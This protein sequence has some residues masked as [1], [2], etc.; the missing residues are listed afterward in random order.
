V[1]AEKLPIAMCSALS[2][3]N[4]I[5]L[6]GGLTAELAYN[7]ILAIMDDD[8]AN[9]IGRIIEGFEVS[10]ET[11][12]LDTIASIGIDGTFLTSPM[13]RNLWKS[14]DYMPK[15]FDKSSYQEWINSGKKT[16]LDNAKQRY[17]EILQTHKP[18][19][20]DDDTDKEITKILEKATKYYKEKGLI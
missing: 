18:K 7:P 2:G 16:L 17:E 13:T 1:G 5:V 15:I 4:L 8:I 11:I 12:G 6:H 10:D 3:A 9:T 19:M 20:L 14:E